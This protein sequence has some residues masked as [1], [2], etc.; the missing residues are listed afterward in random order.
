MPPSGGNSSVGRRGGFRVAAWGRRAAWLAMAAALASCNATRFLGDDERLVNR[1]PK[2][3]GAKALGAE[4]L[5]A[6]VRVKPNRDVFKNRL[7]LHLYNV[8]R[9]IERDSS[10]FKRNVYA[11]ID[12][13]RFYERSAVRWLKEVAGEPPALVD[14]YA[15]VEDCKNLENLYFSR[16]YLK[17]RAR[18][19][20]KP[21]PLNAKKISVRFHIDEGPVFL[22]AEL[23]Y[24]SG[25]SL[26]L[27]A[28]YESVESSALKP[29]DPYNE[30]RLSAERERLGELLRNRGYYGVGPRDVS[31]WV[32]STYF[33]SQG[34]DPFTG[35]PQRVLSPPRLAPRKTPSVPDT[36]APMTTVLD[37][38]RWNDEDFF[39]LFFEDEAP[40]RSKEDDTADDQTGYGIADDRPRYLFTRLLIPDSAYVERAVKWLSLRGE[41][42]RKKTR[43]KP[44]E[45]ARWVATVVRL[46]DSAE[47]FRV[48][49]V[50][51]ELTQPGSEGE[52][53]RLN[54]PEL[55][56]EDRRRLRLP[57]RLL[58]SDAPFLFYLDPG[59]MRTV[60]LNAVIGRISVFPDSI[61]RVRYSSETRRRLQEMGTF[62]NMRIAYLPDSAGGLA[63]KISL[64]PQKRFS[65]KA[66]MEAFQ[67][68]DRVNN[69]LPGAGVN[70]VVG[71]RNAFKRGELLNFSANASV[72]FYRPRDVGELTTFVQY[73][74]RLSLTAPQFPL[75]ERLAERV[76]RKWGIHNRQTI[77]SFSQNRENPREFIRTTTAFDFKVQWS[78]YADKD[79][80]MNVFTPLNL[81]V[82]TT[83]IDFDDFA[84][85]LNNVEK[86]E[87]S[88]V[89]LLLTA[90][91]LNTAFLLWRDIQSRF[92]SFTSYYRVWNDEYGRLRDRPT[93][94]WRAGA[95]MGGNIA[96]LID[97]VSNRL[98]RGDGDD[99]DGFVF[100]VQYRYGQF[101]KLVA[102]FKAYLPL[103]KRSELVGRVFAGWSRGVNKTGTIPLES[104]FFAGGV[105]GVRGWQSGTLG[106]GLFSQNFNRVFP[107][108]GEY[109]FEFNVEYRVDMVKPLEAA[110]FLDAG[111]VWY[112]PFNHSDS[113]PGEES[114]LS[115]RT[116]QLGY[117][118]G[119]GLRLDL[120]FLVVRLDVGQQIYAPDLRD[121]VVKR[122]PKDLGGSRIQYNLAIGYPF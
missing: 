48:R 122:L 54:P 120:Q 105:N 104:R 97:R 58:R 75:V 41:K 70:L 18:Y 84:L 7:F 23:V 74:A 25:D 55:T 15:L 117:S 87:D 29:G 16:G 91:Q 12:R 63:A 2:F 22:T 20:L 121:F 106:P 49:R 14:E 88:D 40:P 26:L 76:Y 56:L 95:E 24:E 44:P 107:P 4:A 47:V 78:K 85:S 53:L 36:V 27:H 61:F 33:P 68:T 28:V 111:N 77:L 92:N 1:A 3:I 119:L 34:V 109:K 114:V 45:G 83:P 96:Y 17:A 73:G 99:G 52:L 112:S 21:R 66:G 113:R 116:L 42:G 98:G 31:Y 51:V 60:N 102:E 115:H 69:N 64:S 108:G 72:S 35:L 103:D 62:Q 93:F 57:E 30:E 67:N 19:E 50:E 110:V 8:G 46:P 65:F 11:R 38:S 90:Q 86:T 5:S 6:A 9:S 79:R 39:S 32:D 71:K 101:V 118:A 80:V 89:R 37:T 100:P 59:L 94:F 10:F 43:F 81:S 82:V 13:Q